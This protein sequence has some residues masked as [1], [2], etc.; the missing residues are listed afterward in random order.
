MKSDIVEDLNEQLKAIEDSLFEGLEIENMHLAFPRLEKYKQ[1]AD[2]AG[3]WEHRVSAR[4]YIISL[5]YQCDRLELVMFELIW[6]AGQWHLNQEEWELRDTMSL[7]EQFIE[8]LPAFP[9]ITIRDINAASEQ[10]KSWF[11]TTY[12]EEH[13]IH[14]ALFKMNKTLGNHAE[15]ETHKSALLKL[16]LD[17]PL[18]L[19]TVSKCW[20]CQKSR[21]LHYYASMGLVD[22]ALSEAQRFLTEPITACMTAPRTGLAH[23]LDALLDANRLDDAA[24]VLPVLTQHL[25]I[26]TKAPMRVVLPLLRYHL[27]TGDKEASEKLIREYA[28]L[29]ETL[30]D[31]YTALRFYR[32]LSQERYAIQGII[33]NSSRLDFAEKATALQ[34]DFDARR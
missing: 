25:D 7:L 26:P 21:E 31:R 29:A 9:N 33:S 15:T 3:N 4:K 23:L 30:P 17:A 34:R 18:E 1:L 28:Q 22:K 6:L 14:W 10:L 11:G 19:D 16:E 20:A 27:D 5:G 8:H 13:Y 24:S 12:R 32:L 2:K